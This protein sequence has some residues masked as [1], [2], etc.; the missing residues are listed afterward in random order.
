MSGCEP[1][2]VAIVGC[3]KIAAEYVKS[4]LTRPDLVRLVGGHDVLPERAEELVAPHGG[5]IYADLDEVLADPAVEIV[6]N[7][8]IHQVHADITARILAG[9]KHCHSEKPLA[10]SREEG[11]RLLGLADEYGV[12][13]SCAPF[14]F[15]GEAQQ[16]F[17]RAQRDGLIGPVMVAYAEMNWGAIERRNPRPI[18]YYGRGAGPLLDVGV[19]AL[20]LLT[21]TL[22]PVRRVTGCAHIV[23]PRRVVGAGEEAG[24]TFMVETPD[25]VVSCLEFEGGAVGRVTASF[26]A[27][28]S[29]QANGAELHG[30]GGSLVVHANAGFNALVEHYNEQ[31]GE[32]RT[33]PPVREPYPGIEW[34]RAIFDLVESLRTGSPQR[35]T[36]RQAYHVLD[37][38]LSTLESAE[39]GRPV[40]VASR[41]EAPPLMPWA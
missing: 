29:R 38:C 34:G 10:G 17:I 3:G 26:R 4:L 13:L 9:G 39:Q 19:Y 12:R 5:R 33:L 22:G 2:G 37:I 20:T 16:T 24:K 11:E 23:Q 8:T 36:G 7:L 14:T 21:A 30:E 40:E 1:A 25:Q 15:L 28:Q 18:P 27:G 32:W 6:A 35:V 41:F 31:T